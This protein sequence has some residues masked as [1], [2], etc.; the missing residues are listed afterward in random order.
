MDTALLLLYLQIVAE[1]IGFLILVY[2]LYSLS[3]AEKGLQ[4]DKLLKEY[5]MMKRDKVF[6]SSLILLAISILCVIVANIA[7]LDS[8]ADTLVVRAFRF[9]G[10]LFRVWFFV[11]LLR[12]VRVTMH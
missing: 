2:I 8:N 1:A 9:V 11:F 10:S 6:R 4:K 5:E 7:A 12:T 3:H